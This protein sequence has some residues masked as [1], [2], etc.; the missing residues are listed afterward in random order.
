M[1][2][3]DAE[4]GTTDEEWRRRLSPT[5]YRVLREGGTEPAG[6]SPLCHVERSG[7]FHCAGCNRVL[8][9][10]D[11]K[12]DSGTGWPS[13]WAAI[14]DTAIETRHDG[15]ILG[16]GG[17]T[18]V[19]CAACGGHLGHV[20]GDGPQPTGRRH[21]INGVALEFEPS[22]DRGGLQRSGAENQRSGDER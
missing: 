7:V 17:R 14:D 20:F 8:Y 16:F 22:E 9:R 6:S 18:E 10:T 1:S 2:E 12:Y 11:E 19:V 5:E 4:R 13:F 15:G 21:C 3:R